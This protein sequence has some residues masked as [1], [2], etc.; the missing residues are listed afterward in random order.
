MCALEVCIVGRGTVLTGLPRVCA[1]ACI[2]VCMTEKEWVMYTFGSVCER[3]RESVRVGSMYSVRRRCFY[4]PPM[5][6]CACA[7]ACVAVY[8]CPYPCVCVCMCW[9]LSLSLSLCI[10]VGV[11][12]CVNDYG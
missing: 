12:V 11:G 8:P 2:C 9:C 5:C 1:Y 7:C 3:E 10:C 6:A 4:W